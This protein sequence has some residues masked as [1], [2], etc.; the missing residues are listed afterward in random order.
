MF[1]LKTGE[2]DLQKVRGGRERASGMPGN[3]SISETKEKI[4]GEGRNEILIS[5]PEY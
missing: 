2:S 3:G 4:E 1:E 5:V